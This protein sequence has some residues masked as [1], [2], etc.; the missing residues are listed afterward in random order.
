MDFDFTTVYERLDSIA[1]EVIPI[2]DAE[3]AKGVSRIPMWVADMSFA[4][5]PCVT[6]ALEER[7]SHPL[8]GYFR[9]PQEYYDAI[10]RWHRVRNGVEGMEPKHIGYE[11]G[12]LGALM[13]AMKVLAQPGDWILLHAPTYIGFTTHLEQAGYR[14][15]LSPM[16]QD[17]NGVWRMDYA[18]MERQLAEKQIRAAV[19]CSPHNPCG[20]VWE[21][22]ELEKAMA[23]YQKYDCYVVS[24]ELWSDLALYGNKHIP[25]QSVSEDARQRTIA[26]YAPS[27][28]FNMAG[29]V[30]SYHV[31]Y[32]DYLRQRITD[33]GAATAYN[34]ANVLSMR[35]LIGAYCE[36]GEAWLEAL[37]K[38]LEAN[39]DLAC[40]YIRDHFDGVTAFHPQG[41]Y[42][43]FV[44]C[45]GWC[46]SH[47][48]TMDDV[49]KAG[50]AAGVIWQDGRAFHGPYSIRMNLALPTALVQEAFERLDRSVFNA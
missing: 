20:R 28:T 30:G 19:L 25:T 37:K 4:T 6:R 31:I 39:F 38:V 16:V 40:G 2:P 29:L 35:A 36:E 44:D 18:D 34:S 33:A 50:V 41:T 46:R 17:E 11:N 12:A 14:I 21:R 1:A 3:V 32:N 8:Y 26:V 49:L 22:W 48:K 23:L 43:L 9:F 42:M 27:K 47:G 24:D 10:I 7:I 45:E 13:S 5:A 15:A